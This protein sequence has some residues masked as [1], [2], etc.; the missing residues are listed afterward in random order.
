MQWRDISQSRKAFWGIAIVAVLMF[1]LG[2]RWHRGNVIEGD[3][4]SYYSYLPAALIHGDLT[5]NYAVGDDFYSD[6]VWGVIWKE[7]SGPVQKYTMGLSWLYAPFFL[8]GHGCALLLGYPAD[9]YSAPYQFWL[10]LSAAFYLLLGLH[11][12]RRVLLQF[13]GEGV[14]ATCLVVLAMGT[15]LYYY[16][17][18]QATM[19]HVYLFALISG[20]LLATMRFYEAPD[21]KKAF[22]IGGLC[23]LITLVRPNHLLLWLIPLLYGLTSGA[24]VVERLRFWRVHLPKLLLWPLLLELVLVPQ[25]FYW[26][27]LTDHWLYYSYGAESF[28]WMQPVV[29]K[30]LF[31]FRNGWLIY[32]P[33]MAL[34]LVGLLWL[35]RYAQA[36]ALVVPLLVGIGT[37]VISCWWCWW[38]G[39]SFGNRVFIDFYPLLA[40]GLG[41]LLTRMGEWQ[42]GKGL[43]RAGL[44]VL[45]CF[46]ALNLFQTFQ[47]SRGI[48]HYDSMTAEAYLHAFG[49][50]HQT[51]VVRARLVAPDYE[52]AMLGER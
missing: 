27:L 11:W 43:R 52:A 48:I 22:A 42:P 14:V 33:L 38:Y 2:G 35:R 7:H 34:G 40:L 24:T 49:R 15:N 25:L 3:V 1:L 46:I 19:P 50:V 37:Y 16:A 10:Q 29:G 18:G 26:H 47:F 32:S 36:W 28:F 31:S 4:V 17:L 20:L 39:G 6:K 9:G 23:S 44:G 12:L 21:W 13:F 51:D 45:G 41:A 8:V 30:V 5:M